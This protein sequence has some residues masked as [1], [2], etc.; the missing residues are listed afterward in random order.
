MV[1]LMIAQ[2]YQYYVICCKNVLLFCNQ[3]QKQIYWCRLFTINQEH[4]CF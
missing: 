3:I 4:H 1:E 2:Y